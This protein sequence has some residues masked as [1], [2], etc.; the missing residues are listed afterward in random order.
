MTSVAS[1]LTPV[2]LGVGGAFV[3]AALLVLLAYFDVFSATEEADETVRLTLIATII[4]LTVTFIGILTFRS[5]AF[6]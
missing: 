3:A 6:F 4:P 1:L 2:G 5:L